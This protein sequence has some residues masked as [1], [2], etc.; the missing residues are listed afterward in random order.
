[1]KNKDI[2][3]NR[4]INYDYITNIINEDTIQKCKNGHSLIKYITSGGYCNSCKK[5][6]SKNTVVMDCRICNYW[7]CL[8]CIHK[9]L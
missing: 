4:N 3:I 2:S 8:K 5:N 6:I 9:S 1:M 7:K